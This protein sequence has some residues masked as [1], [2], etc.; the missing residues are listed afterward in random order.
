MNNLQIEQ[1]NE[2]VTISIPQEDIDIIAAS[3]ELA[4][5]SIT[6]KINTHEEDVRASDYLRQLRAAQKTIDANRM[7][8]TRPLDEA[9][10]RIINAV[11]PSID[12]IKSAS[13]I[14][15]KAIL[16]YRREQEIKR[17]EAHEKAL[18]AAKIEED[19]KRKALLAKATKAEESGKE[20][21]AEQ[22]KEKAD[23]VQIQ[24]IVNQVIPAAIKSIGLKRV[25]KHRVI[26]AS[27]VPDPYKMVNDPMLA[28]FAVA[29][30]GLVKVPGVEFYQEDILVSGRG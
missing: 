2:S 29:T 24:A 21:L 12:R 7:E 22:L 16:A 13:D 30:K 6:L 19:K 15:E 20:L 9:K 4:E 10:K 8:I 17:R 5:S 3:I 23:N 11:A 25:W 26:D 18:L 28:K 1:I 14:L 27:I